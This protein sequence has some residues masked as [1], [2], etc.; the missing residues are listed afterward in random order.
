MD[1]KNSKPEIK[2]GEGDD[3][4]QFEGILFLYLNIR[5]D[6]QSS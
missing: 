1:S 2:N 5:E 6:Y 3:H 4:P